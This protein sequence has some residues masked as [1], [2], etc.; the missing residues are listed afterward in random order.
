[1]SNACMLWENGVII[2]PL[3]GCSYIVIYIDDIHNLT[4]TCFDKYT[5]G[6]CGADE[7]A[8]I[9]I[10]RSIEIIPAGTQ[11]C[12]WSKSYVSPRR[13]LNL[14]S[15]HLKQRRHP[16]STR[17]I[18]INRWIQLDLVKLSPHAFVHIYWLSF[19]L[20]CR[21]C[22]RGKIDT[23][24]SPRTLQALS[25]AGGLIVRANAMIG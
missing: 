25:L 7:S 13:E 21:Q 14:F 6:K 17:V 24:L 19:H 2:L 23:K 9:N 4:I 16:V 5:Y 12:H 1:M 15:F 10:F 18:Q 22:R 8:H 3:L 20:E 11:K